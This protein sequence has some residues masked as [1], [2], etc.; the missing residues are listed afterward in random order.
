MDGNVILS[1]GYGT[2]GIRGGDITTH[3][4]FD[5]ASVTKQFTATAI[6]KLQMQGKLRTTDPIT[7]FLAGV[8]SDKQGITIH[9]LLTHTAGVRDNFGGDYDIAP[10]DETVRKILAAPLESLPGRQYAYSNAGYSLLGAL[11]ETISG[12]SWEQFAA[13]HLFSPAGM[14]DTGYQLPRW[15]RNRVAESFLPVRYPSPLDRPGPYWNLI[16]NGGVLSTLGDLY[17]WHKALNRTFVLSAA[18]A[19]KLFTPY[20]PEGPGAQTSYGYGWVIQKTSRG[21]TLA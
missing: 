19:T 10:R 12:M 2:L 20:V 16:G 21:T 18:E 1:K 13:T 5:I 8:P 17:Q 6:L 7:R 11:V 9:H 15:K 3:T 14:K 4:V